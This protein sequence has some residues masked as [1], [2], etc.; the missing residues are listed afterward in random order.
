M[1]R[2]TKATGSGTVRLKATRRENR[3][4]QDKSSK[5]LKSGGSI[6]DANPGS[7]LDAIQQCTW[8]GP[9]LKS[10]RNLQEIYSKQ[11]NFL[12]ILRQ[13]FPHICNQ[14][15]RLG[16]FQRGLFRAFFSAIN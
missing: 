10:S 11:R 1:R 13:E 4:N 15:K 14:M 9:H 5:K 8:S 2:E 16:D 3:E 7:D 12:Q 6:F